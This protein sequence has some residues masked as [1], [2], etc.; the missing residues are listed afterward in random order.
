[1]LNIILA[2]TVVGEAEDSESLDMIILAFTITT[3]TGKAQEKQLFM[4]LRKAGSRKN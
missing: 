2:N 1:M 3:K 4:F